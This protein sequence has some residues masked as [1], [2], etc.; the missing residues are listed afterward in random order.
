MR[1]DRILLDFLKRNGK[2][3]SLEEAE[4][5]TSLSREKVELLIN[6]LSKFNFVD[7]IKKEGSFKVS[8]SFI[9]LIKEVSG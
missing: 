7:F 4:R 2:W 6:F 3:H 1:A 8:D 9:R 5:E